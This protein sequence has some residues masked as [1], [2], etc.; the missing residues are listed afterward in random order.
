M[1]LEVVGL[2]PLGGD[3][4]RSLNCNMSKQLGWGDSKSG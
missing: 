1:Y 4:E 3:K 2:G